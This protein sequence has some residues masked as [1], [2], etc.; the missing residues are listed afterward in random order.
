MRTKVEEIAP[1]VDKVLTE[2]FERLA[3]LAQAA[4]SSVLP[5]SAAPDEVHH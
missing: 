3:K 4:H 2:Q 5:D 1:I